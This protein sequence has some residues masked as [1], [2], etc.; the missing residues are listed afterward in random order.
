MRSFLFTIPALFVITILVAQ[1]PGNDAVLPA[2][3]QIDGLLQELRKAKQ[4]TNKVNTLEELYYAYSTNENYNEAVKYNNEAWLLAK[5]LGYLKGEA[6]CMVNKAYECQREKKWEE[7]LTYSLPAAEMLKYTNDIRTKAR[8]VTVT[9]YAY[10]YGSNYPEAIKYFSEANVYWKELKNEKT[11]LSLSLRLSECFDYMGNYT[12]AFENASEALELSIKTGDKYSEAI[13]YQH[14][15]SR[16]QMLKEYKEA[17][18]IL[19][20]ALKINRATGEKFRFAQTQN[21]LAEISIEENNFSEAEEYIST[22]LKIYETQGSPDFGKQWCYTLFGDVN[23]GR[24]DSAFLKNNKKYAIQYYRDA[25]KDFT[26]ALKLCEGIN[27]KVFIPEKYIF[28]GRI[29]RKLHNI[30][31][32][33]TYLLKAIPLTKELSLKQLTTEGYRELSSLDSME[34]NFKSAFENSKQYKIYNDSLMLEMEK[35]KTESFIIQAE[36]NKKE[37]EIKLLAAENKL[38]TAESE[39][40]SQQKKFAYSGIAVVL[41]L[42]GYGFYRYRRRKKMEMQQ[43]QMKDRLN[44]SRGLHDD[45]GST[46]SSIS[47]YS[48]VAQAK[49]D[50]N[51][52]QELNDVLEKISMASSEMVAEMNDTVWAINPGNDNMEKIIQ[53][54]ESFARPLVAAR[55]IHFSFQYDKK[56]HSIQLDMEKRKNFYLIFKEAVNNAI[57]YSGASVLKVELTQ[58]NNHF[59]L[60]VKDDGVGFNVEQEMKE[61]SPSLSGNGL[62]NMQ[63]RA[64]EMKGDLQ[65]NSISGKGTEIRLNFPIP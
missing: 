13:S 14:I 57:K 38:K 1:Q 17:K 51:N 61:P 32:S 16:Y 9:G 27:N 6:R 37:K 2:E 47:V 12:L 7:I 29:C 44:I 52:K 23:E 26:T 64:K 35:G 63:I 34:G 53:R 10:Y 56:M 31:L 41:L 62:R 30:S 25:L 20:K 28:L 45:M 55:N 4:D 60:L 39:K 43:T 19:E 59:E 11:I 36:M 65:L 18:E 50:E 42:G 5:K 54:M 24:G 22:A 8:C 15:S 49:S 48:K 33:R 46:L 40:Q 21:A 3:K 58:S